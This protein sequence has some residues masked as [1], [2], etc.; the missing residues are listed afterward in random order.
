MASSWTAVGGLLRGHIAGGRQELGQAVV[1]ALLDP[2]GRGL[3]AGR[4]PRT[5]PVRHGL[6]GPGERGVELLTAV[7][8][9]PDLPVYPLPGQLGQTGGNPVQG[10]RPG[11]VPELEDDQPPPPGGMPHGGQNA[12]YR[13]HG[14]DDQRMHEC[15]ARDSERVQHDL[16]RSVLVT[17]G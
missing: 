9:D 8:D 4:A 7:G 11:A 1:Q 3:A 12:Q 13:E 5:G 10:R 2:G 14:H 17:G 16:A 6:A 15:G